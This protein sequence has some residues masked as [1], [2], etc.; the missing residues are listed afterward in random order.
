[1]A[2]VLA[3]PQPVR[4]AALAI[5]LVVEP[6]LSVVEGDVRVARSDGFGRGGRRHSAQHQA[7]GQDQGYAH[8]ADHFPH[9]LSVSL[10]TRF[11]MARGV[12]WVP[13]FFLGGDHPSTLPQGAVLDDAER[14]QEVMQHRFPPNLQIGDH[15]EAWADDIIRLGRP[16]MVR[17]QP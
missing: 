17:R 4:S 2:S 5:V 7:D 8:P 16:H 12:L 3:L 13:S 6:S 15:C 1:M 11:S 10:I 14:F 9:S